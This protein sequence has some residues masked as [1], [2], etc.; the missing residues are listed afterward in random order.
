MNVSAGNIL[1]QK[2]Q[3]DLIP[4]EPDIIT[5]IEWTGDNLDLRKFDSA[6]YRVILDHPRKTVHGLC[7]LSKI[8]G[9]VNL[10]ESPVLT[11][12]AL[13]IGQFRFKINQ[14]SF[15]LF[16]LHAP[17]PV[18]AC[19]GSTEAYLNAISRWIEAGKLRQEIGIGQTGDLILITGD[20]NTVPTQDAIQPFKNAGLYD[21][22]SPYNLAASTWKPYK[23]SPYLA[24]IDYILI[25]KGIQC[26]GQIR[27][28]PGNSDHLGLLADIVIEGIK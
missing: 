4:S 2:V 15:C 28:D 11:P 6:G 1:T 8:P 22:F 17:P 12:C 23:R 10:I 27:F 26:Q 20:L 25:P 7:I 3:D 14:T 19:E 18:E 5:V 24:K 13:P 16:A 9:E 21:H